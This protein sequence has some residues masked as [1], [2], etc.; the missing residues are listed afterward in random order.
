MHRDVRSRTGL[1]MQQQA[2]VQL[3]VAG[4]LMAALCIGAAFL[5][6]YGFGHRNVRSMAPVLG[7]FMRAGAD[8]NLIEGHRLLSVEGMVTTPR[9]QLAEI[10]GQREL[11]DGFDQVRV[12]S[13]HI[14]TPEMSGGLETATV[15]ASVYYLD[16]TPAQLEA[17]MHYEP[18]G[19]RIRSFQ[20]SRDD[21]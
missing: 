5:Y 4:I 11:F 16:R 21:S 17:T 19:W 12:T 3:I 10:F 8:G 6:A 7:A 15:T 13:M 9:D 18:S 20:L 14:T 2:L 1:P